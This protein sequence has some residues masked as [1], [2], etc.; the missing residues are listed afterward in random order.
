[1]YELMN[2]DFAKNRCDANFK[3]KFSS[4]VQNALK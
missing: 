3:I 4:Y 1:M 2:F